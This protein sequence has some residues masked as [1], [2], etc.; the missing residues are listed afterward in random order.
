[1]YANNTDNNTIIDSIFKNNTASYNGGGIYLINDKG[2]LIKNSTFIKNN[3]VFS[4]GSLVRKDSEN[5]IKILDS[6]F[7]E[8]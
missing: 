1:M 4:G 3:A 2:T 6:K 5:M 7:I 8:N